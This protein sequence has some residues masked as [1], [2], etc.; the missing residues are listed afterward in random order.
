MNN[1]VPR[2]FLPVDSE[3]PQILAQLR[4]R[5]AL[6]L[7][8]PPGSGKTTRVAPALAA[9]GAAI[10]LQ[11][12][13]VA[14]RSIARR[15]AAEQ[16]WTLGEEVGWQ[17]RFERRFSPTTRLLVATEG[18]LTARL[19]TDPLLENFKSIILDEFHERSLHADVSLALARQAW[20][21]RDDLWLMVMSATL[22]AGP[23][24]EYLGRCPVIE[25]G[26]RNYPVEMDYWPSCAPAAAVLRSLEN[27]DGHLL[28]FL[29][30][31]REIVQTQKEL[32]QA[33][34]PSGVFVLPLHGEL[35]AEA[36]DAALA[37]SAGRKVILATNIAE[38]SLTVEGVRVVV[39]SGY[40]KVMKYDLNRGVDLLELERIPLDSAEQ[41][42]GRAG[43]TAP[44]HAFRLW[45]RAIRLAARRVPEIQRID[46][47]APALDILAW[48]ADPFQFEWFEAPPRERLAAALD[49]L[50]SLGAAEGGRITPLGNLL[51]R[52]PL[53]P[54]LAKVLVEA[55]GSPL[56][57]ACCALLSERALPLP[58]DRTTL[59][60]VLCQADELSSA[61][62]H[63][64]L[65][66]R[67][68][69][70]ISRQLLGPARR[71]G[72]EEALLRALYAGFADRVAQRRAP[73]SNRF[74]LASGHG[75]RLARESGVREGEFVVALDLNG[76]GNA[77]E[78]EALIRQA[79]LVR[80]EW[81]QPVKLVLFHAY[82]PVSEEV[83]A[84]QC[85]MYHALVLSKQPVPPD[86]Q[87]AF[88]L[89]LGALHQKEWDEPSRLLLRRLEKAGV[90]MNVEEIFHKACQGQIR[91]P[92][93][94]LRKY[95]DPRI[96]EAVNRLCPEELVIPSGRKAR[97][98][99]GSDHTVR[100]AVR[101]QELF[102]W[103]E[104]PVVGKDREPVI[105]E[106]LAP[107]GRPVQ[108]TSD[109]RSFWK[110]TY[111]EV[112][113]ELRGRYPK[114]AWPEDP[115]NAPATFRARQR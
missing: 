78:S 13:R 12:R 84:H 37:P 89:L 36:Q 46:L 59:S 95:L 68:M 74:L 56:A 6:V 55:G 82:D 90:Q 17:V 112:R 114:H 34:L 43:R 81:L 63:I 83:K 54:R 88:P 15:I 97:L 51:R 29:P 45:D 60:D 11:P 80:R 86:P 40:H 3:I 27:A 106:L 87:A 14:A 115:W 73:G 85:Q 64:R 52:F 18:I 109:L 47:A 8:A 62:A 107:N 32:L 104:T 1:P 103:V 24:S 38:T 44:G 101:L 20:L 21:A 108:A 33:G 49:L 10:L 72:S 71:L 91:L 39:D 42:S 105:V 77:A 76:G 9:E 30:G 22:E 99:Y 65:A 23:I 50:H 26:G 70:A 66:A 57:A 92:R 58:S 28:C 5:R 79:S 113:R 111:P 16:G 35:K 94:H 41:R 67:E 75:A 7:V 19:H 4:S 69:A 31:V 48:E 110:N 53:P 98:S 96:L 102:G 100:L 25:L 61:P 93:L 2:P